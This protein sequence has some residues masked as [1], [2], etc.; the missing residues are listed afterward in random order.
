MNQPDRSTE[1][2]AGQDNGLP[3]FSF[4][5]RQLQAL[6]L[7]SRG[8]TGR[9]IANRMGLAWGTVRQHLLSARRA[10]GAVN[11]TQAVAIALR[12]GLIEFPEIPEVN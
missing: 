1:P 12:L 10:C 8:L 5:E 2:G 7:A 4:T 6:Q 3:R 11:T 9:Q